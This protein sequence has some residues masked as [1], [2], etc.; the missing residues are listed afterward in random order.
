[1]LNSGKG[2]SPSRCGWVERSGLHRL[3]LCAGKMPAIL[4]RRSRLFDPLD[5]A[6]KSR[7]EH[8][9]IGAEDGGEVGQSLRGRAVDK[10]LFGGRPL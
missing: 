2:D 4:G 1:M 8:P 10:R 9:P 6:E 3:L 5:E 7:F